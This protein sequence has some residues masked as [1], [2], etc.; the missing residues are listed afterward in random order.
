MSDHVFDGFSEDEFCAVMR[1]CGMAANRQRAEN[2][3]T[4]ILAQTGSRWS[5]VF[6]FGDDSEHR[7]AVASLT[8]FDKVELP[9]T[10]HNQWN[11]VHLFPK[12]IAG[13]RGETILEMNLVLRGVTEAYIRRCLEIWQSGVRLFFEQARAQLEQ[14]ATAAAG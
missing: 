8:T 12:A 5:A 2:G 9:H 10:F 11:R 13:E 14:C 4:Y 1:G 6:F 3:R 7:Y